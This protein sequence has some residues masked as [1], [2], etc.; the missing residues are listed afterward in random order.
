MDSKVFQLNRREF[1]LFRL[2]Q[3]GQFLDWRV[4]LLL[5]QCVQQFSFN[6]AQLLLQLAVGDLFSFPQLTG[7]CYDGCCTTQHT[8]GEGKAQA[9]QQKHHSHRD[10]HLEKKKKKRRR[11][12]CP[13]KRLEEDLSWIE[14][15]VSPTTSSVKRLN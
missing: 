13:Q 4:Y 1:G 10:K 8:G 11:D 3:E 7:R 9:G 2:F 14:S 15:H 5:L 6:I 12:N